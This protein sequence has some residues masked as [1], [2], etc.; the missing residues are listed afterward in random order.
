MAEHPYAKRFEQFLNSH[1]VRT[2][3][4]DIRRKVPK[5]FCKHI[6]AHDSFG[7]NLYAIIVYKRNM[8]YKETLNYYDTLIDRTKKKSE[9][10]RTA[11]ERHNNVQL[12]Y[13]KR[14]YYYNRPRYA[15]IPKSWKE[16]LSKSW[17]KNGQPEED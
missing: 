9:D 4:L 10:M 17:N 13:L 15:I 1:L 14:D 12:A 7:S 11:E 8:N 2:D 16:K 5:R 6:P 3:F